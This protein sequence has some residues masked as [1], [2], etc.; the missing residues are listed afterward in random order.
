MCVY[1]D[2]EYVETGIQHCKQS[3]KA[4]ALAALFSS[5]FK[6]QNDYSFFLDCMKTLHA[7]I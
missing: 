1:R 3:Y 5:L 4:V 2:R 6:K 7:M